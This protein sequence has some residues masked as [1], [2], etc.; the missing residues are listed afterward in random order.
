MEVRTCPSVLACL[1]FYTK[2]HLP[3][4]PSWICLANILFLDVLVGMPE[5]GLEDNGPPLLLA[6]PTQQSVCRIL[7]LHLAIV[8]HSRL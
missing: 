8:V 5:V 2:R 1:V 7:R 4:R 6:A 3:D